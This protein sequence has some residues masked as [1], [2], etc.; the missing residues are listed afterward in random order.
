[1]TADLRDAAIRCQRGIVAEERE[2]PEDRDMGTTLTLAYVIWPRM[3]VVHV[4]DSR[5]YL[6]RDGKLKQL[7]CDH[8]MAQLLADGSKD[9]GRKAAEEIPQ[10]Q[11]QHVLWNAV[12]GS[13]DEPQ[14]DI[15]RVELEFDD[16]LLLCT[17]GLSKHVSDAELS[18]RLRLEQTSTEICNQLIADAN[19]AGGTDNITA[20]VARF[21]KPRAYDPSIS[22]KAATAVQQEAPLANTGPIE[23]TLEGSGVCH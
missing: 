12:G 22:A 14:P 16:R 11:W 5:C 7:T 9:V 20:V 8:T 1:L 18:Q 10:N 15:F 2:H 21:P 13:E 17:D 6:M 23:P 4:G 19:A 3:F